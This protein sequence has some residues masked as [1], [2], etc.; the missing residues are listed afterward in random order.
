MLPAL[1]PTIKI[2]DRWPKGV[3][4]DTQSGYRSD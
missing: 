1:P 3:G 4:Y 2:E